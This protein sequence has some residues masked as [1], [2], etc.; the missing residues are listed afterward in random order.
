M[1]SGVLLLLRSLGE[2]SKVCDGKEGSLELS[3]SVR[4][5]QT[6]SNCGSVAALLF[7][8]KIYFLNEG[9]IHMT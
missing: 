3:L 2:Q 7:F 1:L 5:M 6:P 4:L 8:L 9:E